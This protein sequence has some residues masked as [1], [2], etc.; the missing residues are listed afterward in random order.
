MAIDWGDIGK[1]AVTGATAG[2]TFGPWG[3]LA[4]TIFGAIPGF[5]SGKKGNNMY[6]NNIPQSNWWSGRDEQVNQIPNMNQGQ[7]S[8]LD[9]LIQQLIQGSV[10]NNYQGAQDYLGK[11][12]NRDPETYQRFAAPL[13]QNFEQ[14]VLPRIG[15]KYAGYGGGMGGGVESS[16]GFGQ[17]IGGATAQYGAD[18]QRLF[19]DLQ[20][21]AANT[22]MNQYNNMS[23]NILS[24]RPFQNI[25]Q[26]RV[27][28][29]FENILSG[30]GNSIGKP[31]GNSLVEKI[32]AAI[33][34]SN[35]Q[36]S[37]I[38]QTT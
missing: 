38:D 6:Q 26:E 12:L 32:M 16:S 18:I 25:Y 15:E 36:R 11:L 7:N 28:G 5:F 21:N 23:G 1:G 24:A 31:T 3:T 33:G 10:N 37:G 30:F 29:G 27:P 14:Q 9:Q 2:S 13:M 35:D 34:K 4:G 17:A 20:Q 22:S 8:I 19:A